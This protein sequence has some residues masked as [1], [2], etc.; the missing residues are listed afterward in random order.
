MEIFSLLEL[1]QYI[2]QTLALNFPD[3]YWVEAELSNVKESRG[4]I[5]CDLVEIDQLR[6]IVCAQANAV[7]WKDA[8]KNIVK[9]IGTDFNKIFKNGSNVRLRVLVEYHERYG[10]KLNIKDIQP[11]FT[12]GFH[13]QARQTTI[14]FLISNGFLELN[15]TKLLPGA[16]KNVAVVSSPTAA[17]Y[18]DF[19]KQ[20]TENN[21]GYTFNIT[22]FPS[23]MQGALVSPNI[24]EHLDNINKFS[25]K[26]DV[27][28]I[29]RGGGSKLDLSDFD[30]KQ[31]AIA[32]AQAQIPVLTGIGHEIDSSIA[33]LVSYKNL[34]T[35][36]S[37]AAYILDYNQNAE[38]GLT[39]LIEELNLRLQKKLNDSQSVLE[40]QHF[41]FKN[42]IFNVINRKATGITQ[43][44]TR[45]TGHL[46]NQIKEKDL[47]FSEYLLNITKADP[48]ISLEKGYAILEQNG[49]KIKYIGE[50]NYSDL[51]IF[52]ND[53]KIIATPKEILKNEK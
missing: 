42:L 26:Y 17:G 52:L 6:G 24:I 27:V 30:D 4:N 22:L 28:T 43:I 14:S 50:L 7:L 34:K 37:V 32:I 33:D 20:L 47:K 45:I 48:G 10:L 21:L 23:A 12:L 15:K 13:E 35:P 39:D 40:R 9:A 2:R 3:E 8:H 1:N 44:K 29:I 51:S 53:G 36:T 31:L 5:Y 38:K 49:K 46:F 41:F 19:I 16:I 11:E 25:E 18:H